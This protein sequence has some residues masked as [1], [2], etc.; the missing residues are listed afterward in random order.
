MG[1]YWDELLLIRGLWLPLGH[2]WL[3]RDCWEKQPPMEEPMAATK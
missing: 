2:F 3:Q 1:S